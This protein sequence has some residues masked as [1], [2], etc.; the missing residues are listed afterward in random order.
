[1]Q[2]SRDI[3]LAETGVILRERREGFGAGAGSRGCFHNSLL[4]IQLFT[5]DTEEY[6]TVAMAVKRFETQLNKQRV[7]P[8]ECRRVKQLLNVKM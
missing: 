1:M 2:W 6:A 4:N 7:S 3:A 5:I 8:E